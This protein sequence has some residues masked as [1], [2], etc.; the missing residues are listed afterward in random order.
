MTHDPYQP[1]V[2]DPDLPESD[3]VGLLL[4][5]V[6]GV[7]VMLV[8]VAAMAIDV[9]GSTHCSTPVTDTQLL[10]SKMEG[11]LMLFA[12]KRQGRFP[13][14]DADWA[15]A[16]KYFPDG[17]IPTDAWGNHF[18]YVWSEDG[19]VLVSRGRDGRLGGEGADAD[20][21]SRHPSELGLLIREL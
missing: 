1:P 18:L 10:M 11:D 3:F 4:T 21:F 8:F 16:A 13:R 2:H 20:L 7:V 14:T 12:V 19:Y 15:D 6:C 5:V 17:K 9:L